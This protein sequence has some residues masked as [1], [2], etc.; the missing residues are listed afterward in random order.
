M[1]RVIEKA[2]T[3]DSVILF[4]AGG[5][6]CDPPVLGPVVYFLLSRGKVM[7]VGQTEGVG[8]RIGQHRLTKPSFDEAIAIACPFQSM[9]AM[10]ERWIRHFRPP[11]NISPAPGRT[12]SRLLPIDLMPAC[13]DPALLPEFMGVDQLADYLTVSAGTIRRWRRVGLLITYR[14]YGTKAYFFKTT[15]VLDAIG[16]RI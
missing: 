9:G 8:G 1:N 12:I 7:Y 11:W 2:K 5:R 13:V 10:E 6:V 15:E 3:R 4:R 16:H 14:K